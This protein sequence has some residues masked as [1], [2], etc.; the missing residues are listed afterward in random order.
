MGDAAGENADSLEF[1]RSNK[2][3]LQLFAPRDIANHRDTDFAMV[4]RE[5][6]SGYLDGKHEACLFSVVL[7]PRG[8]LLAAEPG[9]EF[10]TVFGGSVQRSAIDM[11]RIRR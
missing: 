8:F 5:D 4:E 6:A 9:E 1:L 7:H 3:L 2:L 10:G 11:E